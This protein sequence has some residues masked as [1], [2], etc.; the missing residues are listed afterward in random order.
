MTASG[1]EVMG[2]HTRAFTHPIIPRALAI[3]SLSA[4]FV[5]AAVHEASAQLIRHLYASGFSVPLAFV[6]DPSDRTVPDSEYR[7]KSV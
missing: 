4:C 6:Q 1:S 7:S 2:M 3:L 5:I